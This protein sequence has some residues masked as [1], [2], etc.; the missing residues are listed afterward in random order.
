VGLRELDEPSLLTLSQID[1]AILRTLYAEVTTIYT[2][3][4][5]LDEKKFVTHYIEV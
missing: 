2:V 4:K 1:V 5:L 3:K